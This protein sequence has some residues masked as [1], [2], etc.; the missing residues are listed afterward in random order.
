MVSDSSKTIGPDLT[1]GIPLTDLLDGG[2]LTGR[3][4]D[5][6]V[7]LV[8][9]GEDVFAIGALCTHYSGPLA[10]GLIVGDTIRCPWHHACFSLR[11]GN[12]LRAPALN[13][14]SCWHVVRQNGVVFVQN[15]IDTPAPRRL[16][17]P[18]LPN[19][20]VIVGGGAAGNA[21]AET[22]RNGGFGGKV[23]LLTAD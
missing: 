14:L 15:K 7:L 19:T 1:K 13:P 11:N 2:L 5:E 9:Q 16:V 20:V 3:V 10:E 6:P 21:A 4:G 22:L 8:R 18:G 12:A 17:S 23:T